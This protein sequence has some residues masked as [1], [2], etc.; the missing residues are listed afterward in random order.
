[1]LFQHG[2]ILALQTVI[3]IIIIT[4][5][6]LNKCAYKETY[7]RCRVS[8]TQVLINNGSNAHEYR[9]SEQPNDLVKDQKNC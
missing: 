5:K 1:M 3:I 7:I 2:H 8:F 6:Q 9:S 4:I